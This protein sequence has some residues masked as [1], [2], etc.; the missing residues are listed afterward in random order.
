[1]KAFPILILCIFS[2]L[3]TGCASTLKNQTYEDQALND[4]WEN[5][6]RKVFTFNVV[7]DS[8]LIKPVAKTYKNVVP[9]FGQTAVRNF[10]SNLGEPVSIVNNLFQLKFDDSLTSLGRFVFNSTFGIAGLIDIS[11]EMG[12]QKQPEDFGQTLAYWGVKPGPY[13]ML[14]FLGP[15]TLRDSISL[16]PDSVLNPNRALDSTGANFLYL[17]LN[18]IDTRSR[19]LNIDILLE[20][21]LDPYSFI[22]SGHE[23]NRITKIFDG[24][25]PEPEE[26]F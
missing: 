3:M 14:P 22:R 18:T 12:I 23:Q 26:D 10:F 21:Q 16:F 11:S 5:I 19:L 4:P 6:N 9:S 2:L 13:V 15:S 7:T 20:Q 1:M 25:P 24:D 17:G 8:L